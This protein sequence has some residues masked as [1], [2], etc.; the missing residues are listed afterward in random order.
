MEAIGL[1]RR[2]FLVV[3]IVNRIISCVELDSRGKIDDITLEILK[4]ELIFT[5]SSRVRVFRGLKRGS[6]IRHLKGTFIGYV[7]SVPEKD[8]REFFEHIRLCKRNVFPTL[9]PVNLR[10]I[11]SNG[12]Y[13]ELWQLF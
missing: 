7:Y 13:I 6:F 10:D 12:K 8:E 2:N 4:R 3:Y 9:I 1:D 11:L 5:L